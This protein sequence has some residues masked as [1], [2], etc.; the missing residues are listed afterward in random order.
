MLESIS[1]ATVNIST[2]KKLCMTARPIFPELSLSAPNS[3]MNPP[4][5]CKRCTTEKNASWQFLHFSA[6]KASSKA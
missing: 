4:A 6:N 3:G 5:V 1:H 2:N